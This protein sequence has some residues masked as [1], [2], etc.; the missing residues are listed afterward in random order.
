MAEQEPLPSQIEYLIKNMMDSSQDVWRRQTYRQR[1]A[2]MRDLMND[3]I[4]KY[5]MEYAKANRNVTPF[6]RASK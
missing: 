1:L 6:K 4:A 2:K 5:D 3:K